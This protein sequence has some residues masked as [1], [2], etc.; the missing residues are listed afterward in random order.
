MQEVGVTK[1][2]LEGMGN[3]EAAAE[4]ATLGLWLYQRFKNKEKQKKAPEVEL[5][6]GENEEERYIWFCYLG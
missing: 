3:P 6:G 2:L 4:G 5:Y 1:V